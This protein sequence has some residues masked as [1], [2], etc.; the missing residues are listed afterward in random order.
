VARDDRRHA[1]LKALGQR[2]GVPDGKAAGGG[3]QGQWGF[4]K[5]RLCVQVRVRDSK[6][7]GHSAGQR[8]RRGQAAH[9]G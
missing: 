5:Q 4:Q 8:Q 9:T 2:D 7:S 1:C 6:D 3:M